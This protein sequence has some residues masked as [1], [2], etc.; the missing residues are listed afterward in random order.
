MYIVE[1]PDKFATQEEGNAKE[2]TSLILLP[3]F[4]P[5]PSIDV[6]KNIVNKII[7]KY[8]KHQHP[9]YIEQYYRHI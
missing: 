1:L 3:S 9:I 5:F 7:G 8:G 6:P 4:V 2:V